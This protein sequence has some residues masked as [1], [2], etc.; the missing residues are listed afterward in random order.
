MLLDVRNL[1]IHFSTN[2]GLIHAV[3]GLSFQIDYGEILGLV[4]ESGCG[5]S[6]SASSLLGL[7]DPPGCL[8][9]GQ[10]MLQPKHQQPLRLEHLS[11]KQWRS[12][13]GALISMIFQDPM[14]ALNPVRTIGA[15]FIET[16]LA[17]RPMR[18]SQARQLAEEML[19]HVALPD[20]SRLCKSY[21]FE[22]SGG[23]R[24][25]VMI[26]LALCLRPQ[27]IIADEPTTALDVTVQAQ[28]LDLLLDLRQ[29]FHSSVLL[30]THDLGVA[31]GVAD[32]IAVMYAGF[33]VEI[34]PAE[35]IFAQ[36]LHPYTQALLQA[37]PR[38]EGDDE[39]EPIPG[40]P[41]SML[42]RST[43]CPFAP[44]CPQ[45]EDHCWRATPLLIDQMGLSPAIHTHHAAC[46]KY[47]GW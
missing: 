6:V 35:S 22:L 47:L 3:N 11:E 30:I 41:P 9:S 26:A 28:I 8:V 19:A 25:R 2:Q 16:I 45:V 34:G 14:N 12:I 1:H 7:I 13:R 31:A 33:I 20:P 18:K 39:L 44:R 43:G 42:D 5:K 29:E 23:M 27:L 46:W 21:P 36:P 17:H 15:Q 24:Q 32:R 10:I 40:S 4:G 37:A 38:L